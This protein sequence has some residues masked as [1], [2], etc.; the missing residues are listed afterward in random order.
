MKA[1]K[2]GEPFKPV[3]SS[4]EYKA[5]IKYERTIAHTIAEEKKL[6][7]T[8]FSAMDTVEKQQLY[9][10]NGY[11]SFTAWVDDF[12]KRELSVNVSLLW[13]RLKAGR[14]LMKY[15][16]RKAAREGVEVD[17]EKIHVSP[18]TLVLV[19]KIAGKDETEADNLMEKVEDGKLT[20]KQLNDFWKIH[21]IQKDG[22][23]KKG[24][25]KT[26]G[27]EPAVT[28]Q[29]IVAALS[30]C[31]W[32]V[33]FSGRDETSRTKVNVDAQFPVYPVGS[34]SAR[35]MDALVMET[36]S[37]DD[38][39]RNVVG[40][41]GVEVKIAESDLLADTKMEEYEPF[42]DYSWLAVTPDLIEQAEQRAPKGWGILLYHVENHSITIHRKAEKLA[43]ANREFTL[44]SWIRR[45]L[46]WTK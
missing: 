33:E 3:K 34:E 6:W 35:R 24:D 43:A 14:F 46:G 37:V 1:L 29:A 19:E 40:L 41:H 45:A 12:A 42:V 15:A 44:S 32:L 8:V 20:N 27:A 26:G 23:R 16:E 5:L 25:E 36:F 11:R 4:P 38:L 10:A 7:F 39:L 9:K 13:K 22:T 2:K 17:A 28:E 21:R 18:D 31:S 30:D